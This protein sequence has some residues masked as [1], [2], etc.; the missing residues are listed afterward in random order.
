MSLLT[1]PPDVLRWSPRS[2]G[3][4][5]CAVAALELAC[6]VIYEQALEAAMHFSP[7]IM[8]NG[9]TTKQM[10]QTAE[11]LGWITRLRRGFDVAE[12]TGILCVVQPHVADSAHAVYLWEGRIIEPKD[13]RRQLWLSAEEFLS[14]YKY[15]AISLI[16]VF[17][18]K[19]EA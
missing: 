2:A 3:N 12:D 10:R 18:P 17:K 7:K 1:A 14:H 15:K 13:D 4:G 16:E 5:D 9:L 11:K 6:G 19:E 8:K